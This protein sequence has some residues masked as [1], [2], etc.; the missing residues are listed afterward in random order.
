MIAAL[1]AELDDLAADPEVGVVVI[2]AE[3]RG[4]SPATI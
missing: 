1:Q 2:A 3:G 4:F